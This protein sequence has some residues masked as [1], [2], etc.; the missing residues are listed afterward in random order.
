MPAYR[1]YLMQPV[2]GRIDRVEAFHGADRVEA[3]RLMSPAPSLPIGQP[4]P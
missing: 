1:P 3:L 4:S 2:S